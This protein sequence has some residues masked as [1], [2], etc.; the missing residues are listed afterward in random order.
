MAGLETVQRTDSRNMDGVK[1]ACPRAV[2]AFESHLGTE[3][4]GTGD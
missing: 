1:G 4:T 2:A 3:L